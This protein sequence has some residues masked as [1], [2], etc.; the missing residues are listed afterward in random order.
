MANE[1]GI[2]DAEYAR[3]K[4]EAEAE[5]QAEMQAKAQAPSAPARTTSQW[6]QAEKDA[7]RY[8]GQVD[9]NDHMDLSPTTEDALRGYAQGATFRFGDEIQGA[10]EAVFGNKSYTQARD[11]Q[12]AENKTSQERSPWAYGIAEAGGGIV[13][14]AP[15]SA[16]AATKG[17]AMTADAA[18]KLTAAQKAMQF[19]KAAHNVGK[20]AA[21]QGAV[22]GLGGSESDTLMGAAKDTATGAGIGYGAGVAT[23]GLARLF[24]PPAAKLWGKLTGRSATNT[25]AKDIAGAA[26]EPSMI[27]EGQTVAQSLDEAAALE[28]KWSGM[29]GEDFKL[30]PAQASGSR[31][32]ALAEHKAAQTKSTMDAAQTMASEQLRKGAKV[33]DAYV[34][35]VS[36]KPELIANQDFAETFGKVIN[37][38]VRAIQ[39]SAN[40]TFQL[41]M[42]RAEAITKGARSIPVGKYFK[43]TADEILS[44]Y[45]AGV[46]AGV[47]SKIEKAVG[48]VADIGFR[49]DKMSPRQVNGVMRFW[50]KVASG[51]TVLDA[52]LSQAEQQRIGAKMLGAINNAMDDIPEGTIGAEASDAIRQARASYAAHMA[53]KESI[54]TDTVKKMLKVSESDNADTVLARIASKST[55]PQQAAGVLRVVEKVDPGLADEMRGQVLDAIMTNAGKPSRTADIAKEIGAA[56]LQPGKVLNALIDNEEKLAAVLGPKNRASLK[57]SMQLMQRLS[58]GPGIKGSDTAPKIEEALSAL[59]SKSTGVVGGTIGDVASVLRWFSTSPEAYAKALSTQGGLQAINA[60]ARAQ[61]ALNAGSPGA[62]KA[63][64]AAIPAMRKLAEKINQEPRYVVDPTNLQESNP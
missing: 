8:S 64:L 9:P 37:G 53:E 17:V 49:G 44:E 59:A 60:A 25:V 35:K 4:Q 61:I 13:A 10:G 26:P 57:E 48:E 39:D 34:G 28:G 21:A 27:N 40:E 1:Y 50:S 22:T 55:S 46:A 6:L 20:V 52:G 7:G 24:A 5:L 58:F 38:R 41:G 62:E 51:D 43:S 15:L 63:A 23:Y 29:I 36:G 2:P 16:L 19:A 31:A 18:A 11:Q 3:L 33:L 54:L 47:R 45:P 42:N 32:A 12:R 56:R 30:T 14:T